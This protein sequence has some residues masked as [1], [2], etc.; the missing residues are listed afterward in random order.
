MNILVALHNLLRWVLLILLLASIVKSLSG[1]NGKKA[2]SAGDKKIWLF[3]MIS[4]HTQ[5]LVG[6]ILLLFGRFGMFTASLP[7]G[8]SVM[9]DSFYRFFWVEHTTMMLIAIV[10]ITIGRGQAKK[11]I[12]DAVKYKKAFWF[13]LI[14]LIVILAAIPW[15]FREAVSRPWFP[16]L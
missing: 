6:L 2:L 15:P 7:E 13:F 14:A 1:L 10:L 16:S 4:A 12:P 11:S 3:T 5:F 8:T 9:K